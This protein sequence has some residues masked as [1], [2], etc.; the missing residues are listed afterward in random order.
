MRLYR[1]VQQ[2]SVNVFIGDQWIYNEPTLFHRQ[3]AWTIF[4]WESPPWRLGLGGLISVWIEPLFRW[5]SRYESFLAVTIVAAACALTLL[6]KIKLSRRELAASD[7][8]I[9][10]LMLTPLQY[11]SV[12]GGTHLSHGPVAL[13]LLIGFCI[14]WTLPS[15]WWKYG[16][17]VLIDFLA[18][19]TGFGVLI[20]LLCPLALSLSIWR[21]EKHGKKERIVAIAALVLSIAILASFFVGYTTAGASCSANEGFRTYNPLNY[22][23]FTAFMFA[24]VIGLKCTLALLSSILVGSAVLLFLASMF[25]YMATIAEV[26]TASLLLMGY[27]LLFAIAT[28]YGR[29]CL[30]LGAALGS[31]YV[32]HL[33]P[34]FIG[35]YLFSIGRPGRA[36]R[37]LLTVVLAIVGSLSLRLH[38]ADQQIMSSI[39]IHRKEWQRCYLAKH[40]LGGCNRETRATKFTYPDT[41][42]DKIDYL[43]KHRLNLFAD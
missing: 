6:L 42:Q 14:A 23:L 20:G 39:S 36:T 12:V 15:P 7:C 18:T 43:E 2:Y 35:V 17:V 19:Y 38:P 26:N 22:F 25:T 4:R 9:P 34:A 29:M 31:R 5:N 40:D 41:I 1:I 16:T 33:M 21:I 10:L 28:A 30:G 13:L 27:A 24:N 32:I 8:L 11:E 3:P 37:L